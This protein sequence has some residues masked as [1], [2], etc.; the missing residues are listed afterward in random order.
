ML[1]SHGYTVSRSEVTKRL[2]PLKPLCYV[3]PGR[4]QRFPMT[5]P[6]YEKLGVFYL[7]R[8][9]GADGDGL[10]RRSCSTIRAT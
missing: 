10:G 4:S 6:S 3:K 1:G 7:G 5:L 9:I 8:E 2:D